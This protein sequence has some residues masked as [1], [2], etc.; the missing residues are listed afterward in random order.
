MVPKNLF[1]GCSSLTGESPYTM[2]DGK[3]VH[4]YERNNPEYN[5]QFI[6]IIE[7]VGAFRG[8]NKLYGRY[9]LCLAEF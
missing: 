3:K 2:I 4:L 6:E 9:N 8:C 1:N 5:T 7:S